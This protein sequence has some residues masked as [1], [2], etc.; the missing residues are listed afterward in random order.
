MA[1][2][3]GQRGGKVLFYFA[4]TMKP[5]GCSCGGEMNAGMG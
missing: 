1:G 5:G 4:D 2:V 3:E